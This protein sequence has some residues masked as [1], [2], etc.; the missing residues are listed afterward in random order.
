MFNEIDVDIKNYSTEYAKQI[1][2]TIV[3]VKK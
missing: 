3:S 2:K 1:N